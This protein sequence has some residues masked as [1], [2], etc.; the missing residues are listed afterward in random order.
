MT[1]EITQDKIAAAFVHPE[2]TKIQGKPSFKDL[3]LMQHELAQN[4]QQIRSP[5]S[6]IGHAAL[7]LPPAAYMQY[8]NVPWNPPNNGQDPGPVVTYPIQNLL[9]Q[10]MKQFE[11]QHAALKQE[12]DL[13]I[14]VDTCLKKLIKLAIDEDYLTG[15]T[16]TSLGFGNRTTLDVMHFLFATYGRVTAREREENDVLMKRA[17]N[18]STPIQVMFKQIDDGQRFATMCNQPY[19]VAQLVTM[20][21]N[22]I[23]NTGA[24]PDAYRR[25]SSM[26]HLQ[27]TWHNFKQ[28]FEFAHAEHMELQE[29]TTGNLGYHSANSMS[30]N[31]N[32][33]D[34]EMVHIE[35]ATQHF[36][37]AANFAQ[38][39]FDNMTQNNSTM[40]TELHALR[41]QNAALMQRLNTGPIPV[42]VP[43]PPAT[44]FPAAPPVPAPVPSA[45]VPTPTPTVPM[46]A[47]P[48]YPYAAQMFPAMPQQQ[49]VMPGTGTP[50]GKKRKKKQKAAPTTPYATMVPPQFMPQVPMGYMNPQMYCP[51]A[52]ATHT[53]TRK[54]YNNLNYCW[55]CGFDVGNDH[56]SMTC[57]NQK[58]GHNVH[59]TRSN[60]MN[61]STRA[62]HKV[63]QG[64]AP[65][66]QQQ[67]I[68]PQNQA[69]QMQPPV[70][71]P[72]G[73]MPYWL[74]PRQN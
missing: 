73:Y 1:T 15:L 49:M 71:M 32:Q 53:N 44:P 47:L 55:S 63:W 56:N 25:W 7:V 50:G 31:A 3:L 66:A 42:A 38:Q 4:A 57:R 62:Q 29:A 69:P 67:Q 40:Q 6:P 70:P 9:P 8:S 68:V 45:P 16:Y 37:A 12:F 11:Q 34:E 60:T 58:P 65:T 51:P 35:Q 14:M 64:P 18:I 27:K 23:L 43:V 5:R 72:P 59:A 10:Q 17:Y 22:L 26:N 24:L 74:P 54:H 46:P 48:A 20:G 41:A 2:L 36:A 30:I 19:S 21:E 52:S 39:T 33:E 61:G 13:M 28:H